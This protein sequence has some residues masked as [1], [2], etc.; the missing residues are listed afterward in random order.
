MTLPLSR[1]AMLA[2]A[3]LSAP[4]LSLP[5]S[6]EAADKIVDRLAALEKK[7]GGRLG[8]AILDTRTGKTVS[9]RGDERFALCSTFK[10]LA[11]SLV[12][13][14]VDAGQETLSRRVM[15]ARS[16][17]VTYSPETEKHAGKDGMTVAELCKAAVTLS[18][19]TAANLLLESFGGPKALTD[20]ARSLGDAKT[21]LD[22]IEPALNEAAPG[23]A[24][25]TTTPNAMLGDLHKLV[26]GNVLSHASRSLLTDWMVA[27]RTGDK[28]LRAGLPKSWRVG[29]KTGSGSHG[30][31]NDIAVV[32][33]T[34]GKPLVVTAYYAGSP[35]PMA[36]RNLV[37]AAVGNIVA[38]MAQS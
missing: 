37:L 5:R 17:L 14:R 25:D 8:V 15:F 1:R 36:D 24:R 10:L 19:S 20:F 29:D 27:N 12:L 33:P 30:A 11:A 3:L 35:A 9:H 23:D 2:G 6:A 31:T 13:L 18:D 7:H 22:R 28:R 38:R 4:L 21:R 32:W 16:D 34:G 26:L